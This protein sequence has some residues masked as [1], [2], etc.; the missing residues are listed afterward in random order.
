MCSP[1][2]ESGAVGK[3]GAGAG[4]AAAA[5]A[6]CL[7][8][9][10]LPPPHG[11]SRA[12]DN[13]APVA[14]ARSERGCR[15]RRGGLRRWWAGTVAGGRSC[16]AVTAV[17]GGRGGRRLIADGREKGARERG[18]RRRQRGGASVV[19]RQPSTAVA[20]KPRRE[21]RIASRRCLRR[22]RSTSWWMARAVGG[23]TSATTTRA[24]RPAKA[25]NVR[26]VR[27]RR[28]ASE[29][30]AQRAQVTLDTGSSRQSG[31]C[32]YVPLRM[33]LFCLFL[34]A[35]SD[36]PSKPASAPRLLA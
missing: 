13:T 27:R 9:P 14:A 18:R 30:M 1:I 19:A 23:W 20:W 26:Q 12:G 8:S 17:T 29:R 34:R 4:S 7:G 32:P 2:S 6:F 3:S 15:W 31:A 5:A 11:A 36:A 35:S 10:E 33:C 28:A 22:K 25:E 21:S 16:G 24:V